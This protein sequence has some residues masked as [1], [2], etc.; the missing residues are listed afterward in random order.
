[1][2][3]SHSVDLNWP[4]VV[5]GHYVRVKLH[6]SRC[7]RNGQAAGGRSIVL[8]TD[9]SDQIQTPRWTPEGSSNNTRTEEE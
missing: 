7:Q 8:G 9:Q 1:M 2:W 4:G 5:P 3:L 6:A